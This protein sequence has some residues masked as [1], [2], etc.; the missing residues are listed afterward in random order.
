MSK[1]T[2]LIILLLIF[3]LFTFCA[4]TYKIGKQYSTEHVS[5]IIIGETSETD[6]ITLFGDPWKTGILNGNIVY[7][8]CYEE[9][10]FYNDDSVD[11]RGNTL[12]IE[13]DQNK[14]V[15]NYY[16]NIPG[17]G[18]NLLSLTMHK[19]NKIKERQEQVAW[20]NQIATTPPK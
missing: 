11:K 2:N 19:K 16:F 20:Q 8:Y 1:L 6:I 9:I 3:G 5:R 13:F 17:K 12:I 15:K 7:T 10:V 18:P 14:N 4:T